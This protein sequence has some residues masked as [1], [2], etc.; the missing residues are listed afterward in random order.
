MP[1][2][3]YRAIGVVLLSLMLTYFTPCPGVS[4][5]NF[6]QVTASWEIQYNLHLR[7]FQFVQTELNLF[8]L[9][10]RNTIFKNHIFKG[11]ICSIIDNCFKQ[12]LNKIFLIRPRILTAEKKTLNLV[13]FFFGELFLQTITQLQNALKAT[14]FRC[15]LTLLSKAK[16]I[17]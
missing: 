8:G 3:R 17:S 2:S 12:I 16:E 14:L 13:L 6:E 11:R 1:T 4:I 15:K 7:Y 5:V 9:D 10:F